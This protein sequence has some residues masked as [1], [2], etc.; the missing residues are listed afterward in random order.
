MPSPNDKL[1]IKLRTRALAELADQAIDPI[2]QA[3]VD[4]YPE[5]SLDDEE[6]RALTER[7]PIVSTDALLREDAFALLSLQRGQAEQVLRYL[8]RG[9]TQCVNAI[10]IARGASHA[11]DTRDVIEEL[12]GLVEGALAQ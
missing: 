9:R 3:L 1:S 10:G 8:E 12:I 6:E 7:F 2:C 5:E 4:A 11:D